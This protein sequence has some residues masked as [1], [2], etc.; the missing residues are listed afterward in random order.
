MLRLLTSFLFLC[1]F[2]FEVSAQKLPTNYYRAQAAIDNCQ[3]GVALQWIDSALIVSPRNPLL[4]MK[5]G[6]IQ[7]LSKSY[8]ESVNSFQTAESFRVGIASYWLARAYSMLNDKTNAFKE[9]ERHL[10][11]NPKEIEAKILLDTAFNNINKSA[12]WS[13]LWLTDWYTTNERFISDILYQFSRNE[14]DYALDLLNARMDS[15]N[16]RHQLYALRGEAFF[17]VGSFKSAKADF[18]QALKGSRRNHQYMAWNAKTLLDLNNGK[19]AIRFLNNAIELSGGE[20]AYFKLRARAFASEQNFEKAITDIKHYLTFYPKDFDAIAS[21]A[22]YSMR[23][24]KLID[25]LFQLGKLIAEN[26]KEPRFY[27]MRAKIYIKSNN[28]KVAEMD[29]TESIKLNPNN[30]ES[31]LLRGNCNHNLGK[32]V[33]ACSDWRRSQELGN[34]HA[35]ELI[36]KHCR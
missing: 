6:E 26:P 13:K 5:K 15:R 25:A 35:Q 7:F 22:E 32:K 10:S 21:Y 2:I 30:A 17:N 23:Y 12:E 8:T 20:P 24:G 27:I 3:L 11:N 1:I 4:W 33:E 14:W 18:D 16:A 28:W 34:F 19:G 36:Y 9:L 31:Y 29:L